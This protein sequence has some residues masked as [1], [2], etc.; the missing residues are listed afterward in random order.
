MGRERLPP[1]VRLAASAG[2]KAPI[3]FYLRSGGNPNATDSRSRTL[4]L[5]AATAGHADI[6]RL[7]IASSADPT[8][9]D[10]DGNDAL[11]AAIRNR[12]AEAAGV[13]RACLV[14]LASPPAPPAEQ[15]RTTDGA[16]SSNGGLPK[17]VASAPGGDDQILDLGDWEERLDTSPP[18]DAAGLRASTT[19]LQNRISAHAPIDAD[20]AWE[21]VEIDLPESAAR[22]DPA[23]AVWLDEVRSLIHYGLSWGWVT[24]HQVA[25]VAGR[26][27]TEEGRD[28]VE[29]NLRLV[30][31][32]IGIVVDEVVQESTTSQLWSDWQDE[33]RSED[34]NSGVIDEAVA[35]LESPDLLEN[36]LNCYWRDIRRLEAESSRRLRAPAAGPPPGPPRHMNSR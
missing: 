15:A 26:N 6:C 29:I 19:E 24:R 32:E 4:L 35:F 27:G 21:D 20:H 31:G 25:E 9:R 13:L 14:R 23:H 7:L 2:L 16:S 36:P 18:P 5:L 10:A 33:P 30:L 8:L 22:L 11:S 3:R 12:H 34:G 17:N 28:K 1:I